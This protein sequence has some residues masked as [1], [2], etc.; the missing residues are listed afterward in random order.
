MKFAGKGL[1]RR[2]PGR[3]ELAAGQRGLNDPRVQQEIRQR[4]RD[5]RTRLLQT[6][7]YEILRDL[8]HVEDYMTRQAFNQGAR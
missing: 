7:Y 2:D 1:P 6:A 8:A 4:L 5:N 3:C